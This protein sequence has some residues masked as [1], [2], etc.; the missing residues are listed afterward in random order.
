MS[1]YNLNFFPTTGTTI[2]NKYT[3]FPEFSTEAFPRETP[4]SM[5]KKQNSLF[6]SLQLPA[7]DPEDHIVIPPYQEILLQ[8]DGKP[9]Y[10]IQLPFNLVLVG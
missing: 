3:E 4:R 9:S 8:F 10:Y 2:Q 7:T 5:A 6:C 1:R